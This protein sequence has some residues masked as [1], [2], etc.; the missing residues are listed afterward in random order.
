MS[1]WCFRR[2]CEQVPVGF[3]AVAAKISAC[4]PENSRVMFL[5]HHPHLT[6]LAAEFISSNRRL[7]F[8]FHKF[9]PEAFFET[10][11]I[12]EK[13]TAASMF[14][15]GQVLTIKLSRIFESVFCLKRRPSRL[16]EHPQH[17]I[18]VWKGIIQRF[19]WYVDWEGLW[20]RF[21]PFSICAFFSSLK[22][23]TF[24]FATPQTNYMG[25]TSFLCSFIWVRFMPTSCFQSNI[26][27]KQRPVPPIVE[28]FGKVPPGVTNCS[29]ILQNHSHT[30]SLPHDLHILHK[31]PQYH[32]ILV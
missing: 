11:E 8:I 18:L 27:A 28:P 7:W 24:F 1:T 19:Q 2:P 16:T 32:W 15:K 12:F 30:T 13:E 17:A 9:L 3:N 25:G 22:I 14:K 5:I 26:F 23:G 31:S 29:Q 6:I 20:F 4:S 10:T 21:C